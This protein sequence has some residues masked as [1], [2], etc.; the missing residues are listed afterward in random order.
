MSLRSYPE[1]NGR[2]TG[3]GRFMRHNESHFHETEKRKF[4]GPPRAHLFDWDGEEGGMVTRCDDP[5]R[6]R[7]LLISKYR[8]DVDDEPGLAELMFPEGKG[9]VQRGRVNVIAPNRDIYTWWWM[10]LDKNAKGPGVT[11]AVVWSP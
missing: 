11:T 1:A 8:R 4:R 10:T 7:S 5:E 2:C 3:C 9:E 6:A